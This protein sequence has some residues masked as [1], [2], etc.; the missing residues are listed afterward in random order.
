M[1]TNRMKL[2]AIIFFALPLLMLAV[3]KVTPTTTAA[4]AADEPAVVYKAKCAACHTPGATKFYDPAKPDAEHVQIILKGKKGEKP[5]YMPG[6]AEKG[7]TETE[8]TALAAYMKALRT[9]N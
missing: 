5:P 1:N 3:L 7:M 4:K 8:A 9:A 2:V 6:F